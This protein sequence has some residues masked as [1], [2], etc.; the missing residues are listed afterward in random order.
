MRSNADA[1]DMVQNTFESLWKEREKVTTENSKSWLFTVLHR[2]CIDHYRKNKRIEYA[3]EIPQAAF[4]SAESGRFETQ[5]NIDYIL[6]GL[7]EIQRSVLMLRDYEGY[8]YAAIGE[9]TGLSVIVSTFWFWNFSERRLL[10][11]KSFGYEKLLRCSGKALG[12]L[13]PNVFSIR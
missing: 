13:K 2:K 12:T 10:I 9:I 4:I 8:D 5:N 3:D 6:G 7:S 11:I 1:Q